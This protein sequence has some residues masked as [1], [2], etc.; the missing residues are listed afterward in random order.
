MWIGLQADVAQANRRLKKQQQRRQESDGAQ[1]QKQKPSPR[2]FPAQRPHRQPEHDDD[3]QK[4]DNAARQAA[5]CQSVSF[6][7]FQSPPSRFM[8]SP[9]QE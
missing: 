2:L 1:R 5:R 4:R 9:A 8:V 3:N 6:H 7:S